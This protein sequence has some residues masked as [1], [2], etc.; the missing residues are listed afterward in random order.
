MSICLWLRLFRILSF[1][2]FPPFTL[3]L[4]HCFSNSLHAAVV[5]CCTNCFL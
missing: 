1:Y 4:A 2:S 3:S 5:V